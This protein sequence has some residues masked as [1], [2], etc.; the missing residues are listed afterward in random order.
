MVKFGRHLEA[1]L[2]ENCGSNLYVVPYSE[3]RDGF[4]E[5]DLASVSLFVSK[6]NSCLKKAIK[7]FGLAMVKMW[8]LVFEGIDNDTESRG[9]TPDLAFCIFLSTATVEAA[10]Y[11]GAEA[12]AALGGVL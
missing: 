4:V 10:S 9:A 2:V 12:E 11:L 6:W 5:T 3:I 7:D 8:E 1:F